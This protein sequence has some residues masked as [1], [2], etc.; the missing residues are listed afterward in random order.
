MPAFSVKK[1]LCP[2]DFSYNSEQV[3]QYA[4]SV[5][6]SFGASLE[7]LYISPVLSDIGG[8]HEVDPQKIRS[9]EQDIFSGSSAIMDR[10]IKDNASDVQA[11][12]KIL[13]GNPAESILQRAGEIGADLLVIGTHG[14][15]GVE[16]MLF[17]SV[18]EKVI[19]A[20][21]IPVLVARGQG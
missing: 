18:A 6:K 2:V 12:G 1:I 8:H 3:A 7:L 4:A 21:S 13:M 20:A 11:T 17:G 5:A 9:L 10:F 16:H 14:R 15:K 19:R